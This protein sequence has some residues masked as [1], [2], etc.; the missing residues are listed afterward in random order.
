M[1]FENC[2]IGQIFRFCN[3]NH[4]KFKIDY[5]IM[6]LLLSAAE[7]SQGAAEG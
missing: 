2:I 5:I 1:K 3:I 7:L 4:R 6:C